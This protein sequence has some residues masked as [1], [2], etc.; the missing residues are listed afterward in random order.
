MVSFLWPIGFLLAYT[1]LLKGTLIAAKT[2]TRLAYELAI[3]G[4]ITLA[5]LPSLWIPLPFVL[6]GLAIA[7]PTIKALYDKSLWKS[8]G[9]ALAPFGIMLVL[10]FLFVGVI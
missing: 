5:A 6:I 9:F 2:R 8:A 10:A 4:L 1:L 7:V 3:G